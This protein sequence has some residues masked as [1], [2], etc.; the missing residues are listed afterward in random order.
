MFSNRNETKVIE[1]FVESYYKMDVVGMKNAF[2]GE[3]I[4]NNYRGEKINT[5]NLI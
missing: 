4:L 3:F 2:A 5:K 1:D